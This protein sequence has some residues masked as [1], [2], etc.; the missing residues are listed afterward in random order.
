[1]MTLDELEEVLV[2]DDTQKLYNLIHG[3]TPALPHGARG[4]VVLPGEAAPGN[5]I[6]SS[7]GAHL[8]DENWATDK[9]YAWILDLGFGGFATYCETEGLEAAEV[10]QFE[11]DDDEVSGIRAED[12]ARFIHRLQSTDP[13][14]VFKRTWGP[15]DVA[16]WLTSLGFFNSATKVESDALTGEQVFALQLRDLAPSLGVDHSVGPSGWRQAGGAAEHLWMMIHA[17]NSGVGS[18]LPTDADPNDVC[19]WLNSHKFGHCCRAVFDN[20]LEAR[21]MLELTTQEMAEAFDIPNPDELWM[22]MRMGGDSAASLAMPISDRFQPSF[23]A[24]E[25]Y[26]WMMRQGFVGSATHDL[27]GKAMLALDGDGVHALLGFPEISVR[28]DFS[29]KLRATPFDMG[30]EPEQVT[31]WLETQGFAAQIVS[32]VSKHGLDAM[33]LFALSSAEIK[34]ELLV[35]DAADRWRLFDAIHMIN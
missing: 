11:V 26:E 2:V 22:Q 23:T 20:E 15:E 24:D 17:S 29:R 32:Q 10:M 31:A 6:G 14:Y 19:E 27:D 33:D 35:T 3:V 4:S 8:F 21:D 7:V 34:S 5:E 12:R 9:L 28:A 16:L 18:G 25:V 1:M 30:W 13:I